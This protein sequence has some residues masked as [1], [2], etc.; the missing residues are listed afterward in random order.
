[1]IANGFSGQGFVERTEHFAEFVLL[2]RV[3]DEKLVLGGNI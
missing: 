2:Y 1:M 3:D